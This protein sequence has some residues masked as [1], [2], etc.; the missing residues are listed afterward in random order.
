[1]SRPNKE[2]AS[3]LFE[4]SEVMSKSQ[5]NPPKTK[6]QTKREKVIVKSKD[7]PFRAG[8]ASLRYEEEAL[9]KLNEH[10]YDKI[11]Y[12]D[13]TFYFMSKAREHEVNYIRGNA[14]IES[15][16]IK[17]LMKHFS[18]AEI[19]TLID[20]VWDAWDYPYSVQ[21]KTLSITIFSDGWLNTIVQLAE[22]WK[23]GKYV[24]REQAQAQKK[25]HTKPSAPPR[26]WTGGKV[27]SAIIE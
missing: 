10:E 13:W 4:G 27:T 11:T 7:I 22:D 12:K 8:G 1:M 3:D 19:R 24:T 14:I 21:Q 16:V 2:L 25:Q 5:L 23:K 20:F 15:S 18:V 26:E 6:T 9:R 17:K